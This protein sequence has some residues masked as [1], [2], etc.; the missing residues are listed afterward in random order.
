MPV[1]FFND[2]WD[3]Y[4][5]IEHS[6]T[7]TRTE[8]REILES[9]KEKPFECISE[10]ILKS[11]IKSTKNISNVRIYC[12]DGVLSTHKILLASMSKYLSDLFLENN[13]TSDIILPDFLIRDVLQGFEN[14]DLKML[15]GKPL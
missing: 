12:K 14:D 11:D 3:G 8:V 2:W 10:Y 6:K 1:A 7:K 15:L 4:Y 13:D 5:K 9:Q